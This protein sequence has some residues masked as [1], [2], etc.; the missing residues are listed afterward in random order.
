MVK[1]KE[2]YE[3]LRKAYEVLERSRNTINSHTLRRLV[4]DEVNNTELMQ[5]GEVSPISPGVAGLAIDVLYT[6]VSDFKVGAAEH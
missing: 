1:L 4:F 5:S 3:K 6:A 2:K